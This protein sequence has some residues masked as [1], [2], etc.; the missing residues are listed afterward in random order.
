M[1]L[2][3]LAQHNVTGVPATPR[4]S[5][6]ASSSG[7]ASPVPSTPVRPP[8]TPRTRLVY[9]ISPVSSPSLSAS[10]AFD[11]DA[12]RLRRTPPYATPQRVK[13]LRKSD[14]GT[15]GSTKA[16][17]SKRVVRKK[18]FVERITSLPSRIAFEI[19]LF[20]HNVP[21]PAPKTS[22]Y[23]LGGFAHFMHLCICVS[24]I[25]RVPDSDLGW[26][27]MY[28]E[29]EGDSWFD[30]TVPTTALLFAVAIL[31][32]M[33]LFTRTRLYQLNLATEPVSSPHATFV[34]RPRV[35]RAHDDDDDDFGP[36][37]PTSARF[38]SFFSSAFWSLWR[39]FVISV[40]FL[41]N[42]SP[43][44]DRTPARRRRA[45]RLQQLEVWAPGEL[46]NVL[47]AIYSPVHALLWTAVSSANWMRMLIVMAVVSAQLRA[48]TYSYEAL[49]KD[50]TI[51][52]AEVLHE[53]DEKF[54]F[55]RVNPVRK[56]AAVMTHQAEMVDFE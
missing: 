17:P 3:R 44:T 13:A 42:F 50:R 15:P 12:V 14:V 21:L 1:S 51:I 29:G 39:A 6:S 33:Y 40:R 34:E 16:T 41:L 35:V 47:F 22:A 31:N 43:S 10:V 8:S 45:E 4:T 2:R 27:D 56:D 48:V 26:E 30:W 36:A 24:Q 52:A 28:R 54:V 53:Y 9:P 23:L 7:A 37:K 46:E 20:P 49:L 25:R 38:M 18:G 11:W 5:S 19:A 32:T 55:P